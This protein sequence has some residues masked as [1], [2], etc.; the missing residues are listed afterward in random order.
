M[1]LSLRRTA[2]LG[3]LGLAAAFGSTLAQTNTDPKHREPVL[4]SGIQEPDEMR[5]EPFPVTT[6]AL[7]APQRM[8]ADAMKNI[9][10]DKTPAM[11][12][13]VNQILAKFP[14]FAEGY[15]MRLATRCEGTDLAAIGSDID[16]ALKYRASAMAGAISQ[17]A[18]LSMKAKIEF[19]NKDE[20]AAIEDLDKA[21]HA[22]LDNAMKFSNSGAVTPE[23]TAQVCVWTEPDLDTLVQHFPTDYRTYQ[24]RGLYHGF[25]AFFQ[26]DDKAKQTALN[27]AFDDL[28]AASKLN[29]KSS[30]PSLFK[31]EVFDKTYFLKMM[32]SFDP[33]HDEL[34]K[35]MLGLVNDVLSM[36]GNNAWAL[37]SRALIYVH[38]KDWRRAIGDYEKVLTIDP[39][40]HIAL[41]DG[42]AA[43]LEAG[44]VYGAISGLT[45]A[46]K[47]DKRELQHSTSFEARADAY[48]KS[49]QWDLAIRDLTTA[50]SLQV[51]GQVYLANVGQFRMLYPE[52]A[53]ATDDAVARKLQQT[54]FPNMSAEAFAEG[55]LHKNG[56]FGFPNF[57][58]GDLF[59]KRSDAYLWKGNWHAAKLDYRRAERGYPNSPDSIDRWRKTSPLPNADAY[60]DMKTF[61]DDRRQA[62]NFWIKQA[63]ADD[64]SYSVSQYELNCGT[65][66]MRLLSFTQYDSGTVVNNRRGGGWNTVV[67]DTL[68]EGF[69]EGA[70]NLH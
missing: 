30:L 29:P 62:V 14:D 43:K 8:L 67:P 24:F 3:V 38:M 32:G 16:N 65:R 70:C 35:S 51:G 1:T 68:G 2:L 21:L 17:P 45:E 60:L 33:R 55:F 48:T 40:D 61:N 27:R 6:I 50:I 57:V 64:G 41:N 31:A 15:V 54:F 22:D 58:I 11:M 36:D 9:G 63:R 37:K 44:D 12:L 46:I 28:N 18:L 26:E 42:A 47:N 69:Y 5:V 4:I 13:A 52:Y 20:A 10:T 53:S 59:L 34:N 19:A 66:Q 39:K 23:K 7:T 25:F 56:S 49:Q